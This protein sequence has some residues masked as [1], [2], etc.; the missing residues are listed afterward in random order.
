MWANKILI[1]K[2]FKIHF[3]AIF[4]QTQS[5]DKFIKLPSFYLHQKTIVQLQWN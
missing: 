1:L 3:S 4:R 2:Q 5:N